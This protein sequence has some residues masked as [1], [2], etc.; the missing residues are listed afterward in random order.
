[1]DAETDVDVD[2]VIVGAG[3]RRAAACG[4]HRAAPEAVRRGGRAGLRRA[5]GMS[6]MDAFAEQLAQ[7]LAAGL[8]IGCIYGLL[9][10]GLAFIFGIM[11]VIN[12][13]QGDLMMVGMYLAIFI[14]GLLPGFGLATPFVAALLAGP[15]L[16][17]AG[18]VLNRFLIS[19][20]T[21]LQA[22]GSSEAEAHQAQLIL[23]LG[24]ALILQNGALFLLGSTPVSAPTPLSSSAWGGS[25][26]V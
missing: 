26:A 11:R 5:G 4:R 14:G 2:A 15:V 12:F 22:A 21:G 3:A 6:G 24:V 9:C 19:R 13:A 8:T 20:T 10:V 25:A 7:T 16:F 18:Y 23:T 17:C 1:M